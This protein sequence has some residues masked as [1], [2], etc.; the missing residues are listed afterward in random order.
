MGTVQNTEK[1]VA[2][3]LFD[4]KADISDGAWLMLRDTVASGVSQISLVQLAQDAISGLLD[5]ATTMR[6]AMASL[7]GLEPGSDAWQEASD[8]RCV[9]NDNGINFSIHRGL[10]HSRQCCRS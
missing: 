7:E 2:Q 1:L 4:T 5:K 8:R 9:A 10:Q 3:N 6:D